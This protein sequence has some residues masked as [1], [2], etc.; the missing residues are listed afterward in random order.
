MAAEVVKKVEFPALTV[1]PSFINGLILV[2][3]KL[4][5]LRKLILDIINRKLPS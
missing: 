5:A 2:I 3:N 4:S 1:I